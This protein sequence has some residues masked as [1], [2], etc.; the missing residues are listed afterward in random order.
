MS[1]D[2]RIQ[3]KAINKEVNK[4]IDTKEL[5]REDKKALMKAKLK[6]RDPLSLNDHLKDPNKAYRLVNCTPGNVEKYQDLGYSVCSSKIHYGTGDI[7]QSSSASGCPE[8]EVGKTS[9]LKAVWMETSKENK[10]ILDEIRDDAA[11]AQQAQFMD[12]KSFGTEPEIRTEISTSF[13]L[14]KSK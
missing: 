10:E 8:I 4:E 13:H 12:P 2:K 14:D 5:S 9:S 11:R 6:D 1:I 3:E 7:D